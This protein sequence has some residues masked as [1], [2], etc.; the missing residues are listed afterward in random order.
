MA[1][2]H[3]GP[4]VL[5]TLLS[6]ASSTTAT[7]AAQHAHSTCLHK[8]WQQVHY[9]LTDCTAVCFTCCQAQLAAL[10][11]KCKGGA[12]D[13]EYFLVEAGHLVGLGVPPEHGPKVSRTPC[14]AVQ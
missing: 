13:L 1:I 8:V 14:A 2:I 3:A 4:A 9:L 7:T 10:V 11:G 12:D 6:H 5:V